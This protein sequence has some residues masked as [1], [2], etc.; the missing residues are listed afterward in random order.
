MKFFDVDLVRNV[1]PYLSD[2]VTHVVTNNKWDEQFDE[3][4]ENKPTLFIV[5]PAWIIKC[6][7]AQKMVPAQKFLVP[8]E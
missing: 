4:L 2:D 6:N 7:E 8:A 1:S 3:A 5:K